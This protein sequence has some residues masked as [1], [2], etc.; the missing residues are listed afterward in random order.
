MISISKGFPTT[1]SHL[2]WLAINMNRVIIIIKMLTSVLKTFV[3]YL[4]N[5]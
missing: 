2:M 1:Y 4:K 5:N 3:K